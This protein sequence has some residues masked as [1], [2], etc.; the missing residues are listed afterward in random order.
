MVHDQTALDY[1]LKLQVQKI[2][3]AVLVSHQT[4]WKTCLYKELISQNMMMV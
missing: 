4:Q 3:Q 1:R 2:E